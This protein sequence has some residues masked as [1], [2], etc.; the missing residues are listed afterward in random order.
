MPTLRTPT[1]VEP[2]QG[3]WRQK[4]YLPFACQL[5]L[6]TIAVVKVD[7]GSEGTCAKPELRSLLRKLN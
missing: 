2:G 3:S 7:A 4:Q 5:K 6:Q 1:E